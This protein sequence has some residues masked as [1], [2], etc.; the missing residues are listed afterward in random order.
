[1]SVTCPAAAITAS[2]SFFGEP[3][4][5]GDQ[6]ELRRVERVGEVAEQRAEVVGV[7]APDVAGDHDPA[8]GQERQR[9]GGVDDRA[10]FVLL[11]VELVDQQAAV[12]V[13]DE[14]GDEV[15]RLVAQDRLV[16][17]GQQMDSHGGSI[18]TG[19]CGRD[20]T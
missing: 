14:L 4:A 1:M 11:A 13:A 12:V 15:V 2:V 8:V 16:V 17:T 3:P 20:R 6:D 9:L 19:G 18:L 5:A 10:Q 7:E